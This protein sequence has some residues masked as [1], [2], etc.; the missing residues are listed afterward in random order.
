MRVPAD[1][2][3]ILLFC[4]C[5]VVLTLPAQE[6]AGK[7]DCLLTKDT[8]KDGKLSK[9]EL[10]EKFWKRASGQDANS[11][12]LLD[13]KEI[14]ALTD[15]GRRGKDEQARP[16][17]VNTAFEVREFKGTNGQT[18]RYSLFVPKEKAES[19]PLVLC[20]HG[21]GGNTDAANLLAASEMQAKHP[22]IILAPA[23]D[24][25]ETRWAKSE[26]RGG[27]EMRSVM[28]E[29]MQ[30]LAA[31]ITETKADTKRIYLTGQSMGGMGTWGV[32]AAYA[33]QFAAAVPVCGIWQTA[34]AAKMN[35]VAIWAFHGDQ[36]GAVP[37]SG[38]RDM[39]AA[40]KAAGVKPEPKYTEFPGVGHGS[41]GP[42]YEKAELWDWLFAQKRE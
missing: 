25:K 26:F 21:A 7:F 35:G 10:G 11:D 29:M 12:G 23:C 27:M 34:D 15:K 2:K 31:V 41:A 16:G 19:L 38:T 3:T 17:S 18:I 5:F 20:L 4:F 24:G 40:L 13:A 32:I 8:N 30:A 6:K 37:V 9:E 14:E 42:A 1:M 39:I 33:D 36:D 28:P 22:C